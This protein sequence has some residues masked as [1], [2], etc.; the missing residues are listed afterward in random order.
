VLIESKVCDG[1]T[2]EDSQEIPFQTGPRGARTCVSDWQCSNWGEC[3]VIYDLADIISEKVLLSGGRERRCVD[4][5]NCGYEKIERQECETQKPIYAKRVE[6]CFKNYIEVFNENNI[7]ISRL[8][9]LDSGYKELNVQMIFDDAGYCPYCFDGQ[10]NYDEDEI[11]C[12]YSGESCPKCGPGILFVRQNYGL[13]LISLVALTLL[14]ML[15]I[16]WYLI[17][18]KRM[19]RKIR[20][21]VKISHRG[22]KKRK[23]RIGFFK[24]L[25]RVFELS[26]KGIGKM[27]KKIWKVLIAVVLIIIFLVIGYLVM[28]KINFRNVVE[29]GKVVIESSWKSLSA[30]NGVSFELIQIALVFGI[31]FVL[32]WLIRSFKKKKFVKEKKR[33]LKKHMRRQNVYDNLDRMIRKAEKRVLKKERKV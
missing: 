14:C 8:E 2:E 12:S 3:Q 17:L 13:M 32:I 27:F 21:V 1:T 30:I 16:I 5:N 22:V 9:L 11:D 31:I 29:F 26:G 19:K 15:F 33:D 24:G 28:S 25:G 4:D 6:R 23:F 18:L 7:L 20:R 10:K